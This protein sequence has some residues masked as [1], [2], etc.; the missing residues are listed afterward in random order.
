VKTAEADE[1]S[2]LPKQFLFFGI[3]GTVGFLVDTGVLYVA[4]LFGGMGLY[5]ARVVSYLCAASVTWF[6][7]RR[8]TFKSS[9]EPS[10]EWLLFASVNIAGGIVN[11]GTYAFLVSRYPYIAANPV[12]GVA[13]GSLMGM[14]VNFFL[15]RK[16]VFTR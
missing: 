7:N 6:L 10:R 5:S 8:F 13:V 12:F 11:Y 14:T 9:N 15:S 4:I 16:L 1:P 2:L 3:V